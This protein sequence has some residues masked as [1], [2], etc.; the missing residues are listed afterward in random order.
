M[1]CLCT[2]K[3]FNSLKVHL[4]VWHSQSD[5]GQASK[6]KVEFHCRLCEYM[7]PCTEA[8]FFTHLRS[9]LKLKQRV[10]CPYEGC[11]FQSNVYSTFNAHKSKVE[12]T[13]SVSL[14]SL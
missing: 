12:A 8:G 5:I 1:D 7:E 11:H 10:M 14:R 9:H 4:T 2:F 6:P 3:S 13:L